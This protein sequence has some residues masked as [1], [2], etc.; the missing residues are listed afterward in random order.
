NEH[1]HTDSDSLHELK[2]LANEYWSGQYLV[3]RPE[4]IINKIQD[5]NPVFVPWEQQDAHEFLLTTLTMLHEETMIVIKEDMEPI[6]KINQEIKI[7][8]NLCE[9]FSKIQITGGRDLSA[10]VNFYRHD[11]KDNKINEKSV[12]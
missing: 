12:G 5:S 4:N 6:D 9:R 7:L 1:K 10:I 11:S 3:I 8:Q 2:K